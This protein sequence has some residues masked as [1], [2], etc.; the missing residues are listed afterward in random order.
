MRSAD[1]REEP[2]NF[3]TTEIC[4]RLI[5]LAPKVYHNVRQGIKR[6]GHHYLGYI[7]YGSS[8]LL[9]TLHESGKGCY[10]RQGSLDLCQCQAVRGLLLV[11]PE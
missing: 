8:L 7:M 4:M 2:P 11:T 1:A 5:L 9:D 6:Q 3:M 10:V